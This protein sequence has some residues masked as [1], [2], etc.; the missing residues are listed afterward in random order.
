MLFCGRPQYAARLVRVERNSLI[1]KGALL[2]RVI[3]VGKVILVNGLRCIVNLIRNKVVT[4][5]PVHRASELL[6][7]LIR[8]QQVVYCEVQF[9]KCRGLYSSRMSG[10]VDA[11]A[12]VLD[13]SQD[14]VIVSRRT[15]I[16]QYLRIGGRL[17]VGGLVMSIVKMSNQYVELKIPNFLRR[18][19]RHIVVGATIN[20]EWNRNREKDEAWLPWYEGLVEMSIQ[21]TKS[22]ASNG[23]LGCVLLNSSKEY[24][25]KGEYDVLMASLDPDRHWNL[26]IVLPVLPSNSESLIQACLTGMIAKVIVGHSCRC[27]ETLGPYLKVETGYLENEIERRLAPQ[28]WCLTNDIPYTILCTVPNQQSDYL[29]WGKVP[30]CDAILFWNKIQTVVIQRKREIT[31]YTAPWSSIVRKLW[32]NGIRVAVVL[33]T[34]GEDHIPNLKPNLHIRVDKVHTFRRADLTIKK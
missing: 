27:Q 30:S 31:T 13:I 26:I 4:L 24:I 6:M 25:K 20:I 23:Q 22:F 16:P 17:Y 14:R 12:F 18:F 10:T 28:L 15:M 1:I 9:P 11:M 34:E 7:N 21:T 19:S 5:R 29:A 32:D 8:L 33:H 3:T 2:V